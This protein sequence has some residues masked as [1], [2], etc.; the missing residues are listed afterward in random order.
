MTPRTGIYYGVV[1]LPQAQSRGKVIGS[2]HLAIY[3]SYVQCMRFA[4]CE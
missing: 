1:L 2:V 4:F 3:Y